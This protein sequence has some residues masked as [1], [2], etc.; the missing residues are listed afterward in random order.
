MSYV[1]NTPEEQQAMLEH[2]GLSSIEDLLQPVPENIRLQQPLNLPSA[3]TEPDLKRLL[4]RMAQKNKSLDTTISFLGAGTYDHTI[5]SVV[6]H[7]QRRSE[8]VTSY[9]PYQPEVSQGML[10]AIY[11]FQTMVS[12][13]TGM[14]IANASLYDGSTAVVEAALMAL[15]PGGKGEIVI[16]AGVDPQYR[17]V[18]HTYAFAR[19]FSVK[20]VPTV[21]GVTSLPDLDAAVGPA[22]A[23]V[24]IQQP[25]FFGCVE[26]VQAIEPLAHKGKTLFV[27][28]ITEPASL[29]IL[30]PPGEYNVD[31]AVGELMSFGNPMSYGAPALGFIASKQKFMRLLPGRLVGQTIEE[32]GQKQTGYVL[33]L[34]TREQH[35][36]RD[37]ATSNICTNQS[38]LAVGATIFLATLGKQGFRELAELCLQK[39]HYAFRQ[40][41]ALP[42][43]EAAFKGPFFDEFVIKTPVA[44]SK[45]QQHFERANIIGGYPLGESYPG[46]DDHMLFCVTEVRTKEDIDYLVKVLQ[47]V[48]A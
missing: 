10:Q 22:T 12:Q 30:A 36:R 32:G 31:L 15:G 48:Q 14:D 38:L 1:P 17:R 18:L 47:E 44:A 26:D 27:T 24:I 13:I 39:A 4:T 16:S 40:I 37:R 34:Q 25:N 8:F 6:S 20:E 28:A 41:T 9:T 42:G 33:T 35:I 23:A 45:L 21:N 19:G 7:L 46:M 43:F 2:M 5:P 29:G 11:E 3:L